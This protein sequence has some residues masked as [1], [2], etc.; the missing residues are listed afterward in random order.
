MNMTPYY[1]YTEASPPK[2]AVDLLLPD[3][4][5]I[6]VVPRQFL[7]PRGMTFNNVSTAIRPIYDLQTC[8]KLGGA[9]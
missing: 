2:S 1:R 3:A 7:I 6:R 9:A 4:P 5:K 8:A